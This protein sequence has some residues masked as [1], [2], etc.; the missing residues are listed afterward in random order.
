MFSYWAFVLVGKD[1]TGK[2]TIQRHIASE[3]C[4]IPDP[5]PLPSNSYYAVCDSRL[6]PTLATLFVMNR[7]LNE[8]KFTTVKE[9]FSKG[10]RDA[11]LC[12]MAA[13]SDDLV[14]IREMIE[15]LRRRCYNVA[16]VFMSNDDFA[17]L[18]KVSMLDW[19]ERLWFMNHRVQEQEEVEEHLW[20]RARDFIAFLVKRSAIW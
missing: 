10:F 11:D 6:P 8:Q 12:V 14:V 3:L 4:N 18:S 20:R 7:S 5:K 17:N 19:D 13:H 16:G 9:F 2:T 15:E 1:R